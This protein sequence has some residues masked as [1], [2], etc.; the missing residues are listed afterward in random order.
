HE[1]QHHVE[2]ELTETEQGWRIRIHCGQPEILMTQITF[3]F[4]KEG[5]LSGDSLSS[6]ATGTLFWEK[7]TSRLTAG[8]DW[9][10]VDGG[11]H[12]HRAKVLSNTSYPTDCQTLIV[13][14]MTPYDK[15]FD[16]RL[17]PGNRH[18]DKREE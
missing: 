16:I 17:S 10:E 13:N 4:G 6:A 5:V 9:I 18:D 12:E 3:V 11:A 14:L 8:N 7:G 2:V 1:Q 15:T